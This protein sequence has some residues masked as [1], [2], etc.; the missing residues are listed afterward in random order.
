MGSNISL[1]LQMGKLMKLFENAII[2]VGLFSTSLL[3]FIIQYFIRIL[4]KI[5]IQCA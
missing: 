3:A 1:V 2:I 5:K 4:Y